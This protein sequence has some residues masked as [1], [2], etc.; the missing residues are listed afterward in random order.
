[1]KT[2]EKEPQGKATL[3][4]LAS[5]YLWLERAQTEVPTARVVK[6]RLSKLSMANGEL[7]AAD[8]LPPRLPRAT[9][10]AVREY[11][12]NPAGT[13]R[14]KK[15]EK[16]VAS[17]MSDDERLVLKAE[18]AADERATAEAK[19]ESAEAEEVPKKKAAKR[20]AAEPE[21]SAAAAREELPEDD[22]NAD[23][24]EVTDEP[25]G[26]VQGNATESTKLF[27]E[28]TDPRAESQGPPARNQLQRVAMLK[29]ELEL[30]PEVYTTVV[31][32][33][34]VESARDLTSAQCDMLIKDLTDL[35]DETERDKW[36]KE[37]LSPKK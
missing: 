1:M 27:P 36:A 33:Y 5:L 3:S 35:M 10:A 25:A 28:G 16:V 34:G 29:K 11:I 37:A 2:S 22:K 9:V 26:D 30:S 7:Q 6:S 17:Q 14:L 24:A 4:E 18:I 15:D 20:K 31:R 21:T 13:R 19:K 32:E 8:V 12:A 23:S